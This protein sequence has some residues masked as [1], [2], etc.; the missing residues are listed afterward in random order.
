VTEDND[1]KTLAKLT[2]DENPDVR[3]SVAF[4][5]STPVE[6]LAKLAKDKDP[7]VRELAVKLDL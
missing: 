1:P 6:V 3:R 2:N 5:P 4:N 7:I